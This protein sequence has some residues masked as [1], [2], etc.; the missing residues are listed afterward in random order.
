MPRLPRFAPSGFRYVEP[1]PGE[2][3]ADKTNG[4]QYRLEFLTCGRRIWGSGIGIGSHRRACKGKT[5]TTERR[6]PGVGD[7][8]TLTARGTW[9]TLTGK[10]GEAHT[11]VGIVDSRT[12]D[13]ITERMLDGYGVLI[14][15]EDGGVWQLGDGDYT[16]QKEA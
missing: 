15:R 8:I 2:R 12:S 5:V 1:T 6:L 16:F 14:R 4:R 10:V 13:D 9:R 11:V 3:A 7:T